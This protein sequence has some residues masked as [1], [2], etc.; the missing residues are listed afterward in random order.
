MRIFLAASLIVRAT[1]GMR[2]RFGVS[3]CRMPIKTVQF[4]A[5]NGFAVANIAATLDGV[6]TVLFARALVA[7]FAAPVFA[8]IR[9]YLWP[10]RPAECSGSNTKKFFNDRK[11]IFTQKDAA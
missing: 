4:A 8:K 5:M 7:V 6:K 11:I 1:G 10:N 3:F 9:I 2:F